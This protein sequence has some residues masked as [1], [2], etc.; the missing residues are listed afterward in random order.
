VTDAP[1]LTTARLILR[2]V[3][4]TD[5]DALS[6]IRADKRVGRFTG[7]TRTRQDIWFTM[8][9]TVGLWHM[10]GYGYW[11][12]CEA[13]TEVI[14][15]EV[16]FADFMRGLSPDISMCP[17]SGWIIAPKFWGK[18]YASEAV[19]A[20]HDWLDR[21]HPGRSTC[22]IEPRNT[23][24]IKIAEKCAYTELARTE[25]E[26]SSIIIFERQSHAPTTK[27]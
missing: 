18:G 1:T 23:A 21:N 15:G 13:A 26:D 24:S 27:P 12:V 11:T 9:R 14:I 10:L 19:S 6:A 22:I 3:R 17:E 2:P 20:A 7:G 16:G 5:L 25:F 4:I 8:L